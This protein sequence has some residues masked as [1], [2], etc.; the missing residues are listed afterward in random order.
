M[1]PTAAPQSCSVMGFLHRVYVYAYIIVHMYVCVIYSGDVHLL[2][3]DRRRNP[4]QGLILV[5]DTLRILMLTRLAVRVEKQFHP[6]AVW[7]AMC[8]L[9]HLH[10]SK[11]G[12]R[13]M[14]KMYSS[15]PD[16]LI[17]TLAKKKKYILT[18]ALTLHFYSKKSTK[19]LKTISYF[20][21]SFWY[22][23]LC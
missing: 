7:T 4:C 11:V 2:Q 20:R 13:R 18:S 6:S 3:A 10:L 8:S 17:S 23:F 22:Y 12:G 9:A 16:C 5:T 19:G 21:K 1:L 15:Q 14:R